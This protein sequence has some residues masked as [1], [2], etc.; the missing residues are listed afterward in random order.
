MEFVV[1]TLI[2]AFVALVIFALVVKANRQRRRRD[3]LMQ[4]AARN[5]WT[6]TPTPA[7][8][9]G[10]RLPG[11]NRKGVSIALSATMGGRSVSVAE[12]SYTENASGSPQTHQFIVTVVRLAQ[13]YPPVAVQPRNPLS[14]LAKLGGGDG[15]DRQFKVEGAEQLVG[16]TLAAEHLAGTVPPWSL[17]RDELLAYRHGRLDRPDQIP[18]LV[19]PLLR[20]ADLLGR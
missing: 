8:D 16:P 1:L 6:V 4:W 12:Y 17:Y 7:V 19:S 11:G 18:A 15:F 5:G 3:Q 2:I 9:W 14:K 20:V 10:V 13:S